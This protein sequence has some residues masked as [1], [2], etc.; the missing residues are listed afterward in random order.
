MRRWREADAVKIGVNGMYV[1]TNPAV[2]L[3]IAMGPNGL[4]IGVQ[5]V[6][7]FGHDPVLFRLARQLEV[8]YQWPQ[9]TP[10]VW[11]AAV[12]QSTGQWR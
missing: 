9:R 6:A 12:E 7:P 5:L 2:S 1:V 8:E 3:P 11:A 10:H 4:P